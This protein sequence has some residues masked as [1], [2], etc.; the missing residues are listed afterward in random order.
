MHRAARALEAVVPSE[1][2]YA[3]SLGSQQANRHLHVH[4]AALPPGTP[5]AQQQHAALAAERGVLVMPAVET[6]RLA[7]ALRRA[8]AGDV[9]AADP[10]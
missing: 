3:V 10:V 2:T 5:L 4:V 7:E 6:A 9:L 1:R 8:L